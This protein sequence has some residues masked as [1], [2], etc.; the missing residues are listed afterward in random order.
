MITVKSMTKLT[1]AKVVKSYP[2]LNAPEDIRNEDELKAWWE[3]QWSQERD[4]LH[5]AHFYRVG[6]LLQCHV[7]PLG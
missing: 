3:K 6:K 4:V 1:F 7:C 5:K 2:K